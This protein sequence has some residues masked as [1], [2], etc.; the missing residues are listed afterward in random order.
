MGQGFGAKLL[1]VEE[2]GPVSAALQIH[3]PCAVCSP[4]C[5]LYG[6]RA[7]EFPAPAFQHVRYATHET[8]FHR[9]DPCSRRIF[10]ICSGIVGCFWG[11]RRPEKRCL[12]IRGPHDWVGAECWGH[13]V[14]TCEAR[15]LKDVSGWWI[16]QDEWLKLIRRWEVHDRYW[17]REIEH[18]RRL[19]EWQVVLAHGSVRARV[20]W[21]LL[22]LAERFG[23]AGSEGI[24]VPLYLTQ[25]QQAE[26]A[27]ATRPRVSMAIEHF[28]GQGW[29]SC[30]RTGFWI[31]DREALAKQSRES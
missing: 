23:R 26:L 6:L 14:W 16:E 3:D 2:V 18:L 21:Q 22:Q 24:F 30:E 10:L 1:T 25:E 4:E 29:L 12:E 11:E 28:Q 27:G 17:K 7:A 13:K 15:T 20:A 31:K 5:L 8:L 9:D 19:H